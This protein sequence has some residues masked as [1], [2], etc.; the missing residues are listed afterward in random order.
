MLLF[1]GIIAISPH[2]FLHPFKGK[3]VHHAK[4]AMTFMRVCGS[5]VGFGGAKFILKSLWVL[6]HT[7]R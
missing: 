5:I 7:G 4:G 1:G 6:W 2:R 3:T